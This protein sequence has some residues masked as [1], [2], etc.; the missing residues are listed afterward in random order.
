[1]RYSVAAE[2]LPRSVKDEAR[3]GIGRISHGNL[4]THTGRSQ[5]DA[6]YHGNQRFA[7]LLD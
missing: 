6:D 7:D 5:L 1:M 4:A 2:R 3:R